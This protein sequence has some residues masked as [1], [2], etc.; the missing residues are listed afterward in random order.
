MTTSLELTSIYRIPLGFRDLGWAPA[1]TRC[2]LSPSSLWCRDIIACESFDN[3]EPG[4]GEINA[5]SVSAWGEADLSAVVWSLDF[6]LDKTA[7]VLDLLNM[8]GVV[9]LYPSE[10]TA[11]AAFALGL[12][13]L[14][15]AAC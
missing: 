15:V 3:I 8:Y 10:V 7:R 2:L 9:L 11:C 14:R 13:E 12:L 4:A 1:L 6:R 5:D